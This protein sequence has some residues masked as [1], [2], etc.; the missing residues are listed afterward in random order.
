MIKLKWMTMTMTMTDIKISKCLFYS[1]SARKQRGFTLVELLITVAVVGILASVAYPSD[2]DFVTSSNRTE[3]QR[4]L[5]RFANLQEQY[6]VDYR[7]Y[8]DDLTKLG[9]STKKVLT[10]NNHYQIEV[11]SADATAF[12]LMAVAQG[13]QAT[14]DDSTCLSLT[15]TQVGVKGPDGCWD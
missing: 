10:E 7:T 3:G 6:F 9:K 1:E 5:L 4:E 8:G 13:S 14:N 15:V 2:V 12:V 11:D